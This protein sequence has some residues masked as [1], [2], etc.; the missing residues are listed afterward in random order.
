MPATRR[1]CSSTPTRRCT[2]PSRAARTPGAASPRGR[3]PTSRTR[4]RR[5]RRASVS[6]A[7]LRRGRPGGA[8]PAPGATSAGP[9]DPAAARGRGTPGSC[10]RAAAAGLP[11]A[12]AA[13]AAGPRAAA[14]P[15]GRWRH[16]TMSARGG[17]RAFSSGGHGTE[18]AETGC[19][20]WYPSWYREFMA[21]LKTRILVVDDDQRLRDLLV[22]Y[23]G[24]E[25]YEVKAV[26]DAAGMDKQ[27][28]LEH[29]EV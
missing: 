13:A 29:H 3:R 21:E 28:S 23:L 11:G 15:A 17:R 5:K 2:R 24:G 19:N 20:N 10:R 4:T 12:S 26:A 8:F 27:L 22:R 18:I 6:V 25:G 1:R 16:P 7:C 9:A 14:C